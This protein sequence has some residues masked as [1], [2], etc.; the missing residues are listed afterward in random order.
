MKKI[1]ISA[2]LPV[3]LAC[4]QTANAGLFDDSEARKEIIKL[5]GT[6][7]ENFKKMGEL[8]KQMQFLNDSNAALE[9]R[10]QAL[11]MSLAQEQAKT[12]ALEQ[13]IGLLVAE[14]VGKQAPQTQ[15][16]SNAL[17]TPAITAPLVVE[18]PAATQNTSYA[19]SNIGANTVTNTDTTSTNTPAINTPVANS[20]TSVST[21]SSASTTLTTTNTS[22]VSEAD[23]TTSTASDTEI[24]G[25]PNKEIRVSINNQ[26]FT[27][28]LQ[29]K[30][31]YEKVLQA[32]N[33]R[34]YVE[35]LSDLD[36]FENKFPDSGYLPFIKLIRAHSLFSQLDYPAA[37]K[38]FRSI[39]ANMPG[40]PKTPEAI[41]YM[42][43]CQIFSDET[44][45]AQKA[46]NQL[47]SIYPE[48]TE[49]EEAKQILATL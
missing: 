33:G 41:L 17:V 34:K 42:A 12:I 45:A 19:S 48:A 3:A 2:L 46:L 35:V 8:V 23:A 43:K 11:E 18:K 21:V 29:Q 30:E 49:S 5:Q 31:V 6:S 4:T 28:T 7:S 16:Q 22:S 20:N 10:V 36:G 25:D 38:E 26:A 24:K 27:T 32:Y 44:T 39:V 15:N 14:T 37:Y 47:I 1:V 9:K 40:H 13:K